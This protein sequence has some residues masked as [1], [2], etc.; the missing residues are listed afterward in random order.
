MA[1]VARTTDP[2]I[3]TCGDC[4]RTEH[5]HDDVPPPGWDVVVAPLPGYGGVIRCPDCAE[6][7]EQQHFAR[8][9]A[10]A[11]LH[12][13]ID[14]SSVPD[15]AGRCLLARDGAAFR[16]VLVDAGL[17]RTP[18]GIEMTPAGAIGLAR[19]LIRHVELALN[20]GTLGGAS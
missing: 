18:I 3:F 5:R 12:G 13:G 20:P 14:V 6:M 16:I 15:L 11:P 10:T 8:H 7:V 4:A 19:D 1:T 9:A 17:E 2:I